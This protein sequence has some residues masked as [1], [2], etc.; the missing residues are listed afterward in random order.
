[1]SGGAPGTGSAMR[2]RGM[3]TSEELAALVMA[4]TRPGEAAEL[5]GYDRWR[6]GR[7]AALAMRRR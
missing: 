6:A 1:M 7:L 4:L 3:P 2:V 5:S